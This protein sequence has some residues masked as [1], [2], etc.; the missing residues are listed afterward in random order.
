[1]IPSTTGPLT[2]S[3]DFFLLSF[4]RYK[5]TKT[6]HTR[7]IL[8]APLYRIFLDKNQ[9]LKTSLL[10]SQKVGGRFEVCPETGKAEAQPHYL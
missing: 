5:F 10:L 7:R 6:H 2:K 3:L 4:R 9:P 1:M 8:D